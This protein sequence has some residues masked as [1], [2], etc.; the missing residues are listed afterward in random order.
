MYSTCS[1]GSKCLFTHPFSECVC[2]CVRVCMCILVRYLE[3]SRY[4]GVGSI[5]C[6][7]GVRETHVISSSQFDCVCVSD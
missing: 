1:D 4:N 2:V 7:K 6:I 5:L 3:Y